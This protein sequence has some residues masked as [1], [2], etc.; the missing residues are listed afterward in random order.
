MDVTAQVSLYPLRQARLSPAIERV[1]AVFREHGLRVA[2]GAMS[3]LVSGG[4]DTVFDALK[5][6]FQVTA[7]QGD[8]VMVITLSNACPVPGN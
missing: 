6:A 2:P 8:M 4:H 5:Q 3:T 7:E 1:L